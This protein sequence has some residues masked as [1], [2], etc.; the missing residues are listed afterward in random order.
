MIY[1]NPRCS[2]CRAALALLAERGIAPQ[3]VEYLEQPPSVGELAV[4]L[5]RLGYTDA[6]QLMRSGEAEYANLALDNPALSQEDL[7][8]ALAE[9][10]MLIERPVF[11]HRDRAVI[12]R[13]PEKV[14]ELL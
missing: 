1:Y 14:L 8:A 7:L 4:L 5:E 12:G 13:P 9:H 10:P 2:K 3:V 6:R 11:V